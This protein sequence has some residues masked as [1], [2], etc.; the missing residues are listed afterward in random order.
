MRQLRGLHQGARRLLQNRPKAIDEYHLL[1]ALLAPTAKRANTLPYIEQVRRLRQLKARP[2]ISE[3]TSEAVNMAVKTAKDNSVRNIPDNLRRFM[4]R[5]ELTSRD[6]DAWL[7]INVLDG[8]DP[9][10]AQA[11]LESAL[12]DMISTARPTSLRALMQFLAKYWQQG[13]VG[14]RPMIRVA[15]AQALAVLNRALEVHPETHYVISGPRQVVPQISIPDLPKFERFVGTLFEYMEI[16]KPTEEGL[17]PVEDRLFAL[18]ARCGAIEK[19]ESQLLEVYGAG[20]SLSSSSVDEFLAALGRHITAQREAFPGPPH[21]FNEQVREELKEFAE[22]FTAIRPSPATVRFLLLWAENLDEF[23]EV[24]GIAENRPDIWEECQLDFIQALER[25]C[26]PTGDSLPLMSYLFSLLNRVA[27]QSRLS[28]ETVEYAVVLAAKH[29]NAAGISRALDMHSEMSNGTPVPV[30]V[31][32]DILESFPLPNFPGSKAAAPEL[33]VHRLR[34]LVTSA[35]L[36]KYLGALQRCGY[37]D[38]I[39]AEW[40]KDPELTPD[41]ALS[42]VAGFMSCDQSQLALGVIKKVLGTPQQVGVVQA[43]ASHSLIA[44]VDLYPV[45]MQYIRTN[46][47]TPSDIDIVFGNI[48]GAKQV[49]DGLMDIETLWPRQQAL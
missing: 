12:M 2:S 30:Q 21:Q 34:P 1:E 25:A 3:T 19:T 11:R 4:E 6:I 35:L 22:I 43:V 45:V 29:G 15:R 49:A 44:D 37:L 42:F 47:W 39:R 23:W 48:P 13:Y 18:S 28:L 9:F 5:P 41:L 17:D 38:Q 8:A 24:V 27:A 10:K 26:E 40:E 36:P 16:A 46:G 33:L 31:L 32:G 20:R 7:Q 14:T